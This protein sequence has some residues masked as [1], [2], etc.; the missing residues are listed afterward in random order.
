MKLKRAT[1]MWWNKAVTRE[2][3][4]TFGDKDKRIRENVTEGEQG[5]FES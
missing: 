5:G 1:M 4:I 3:K 2:D